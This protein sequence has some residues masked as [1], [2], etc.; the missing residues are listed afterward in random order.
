MLDSCAEYLCHRRARV[1]HKVQH[2]A[3][4]VEFC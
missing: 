3:E 2:P 1:N 4:G